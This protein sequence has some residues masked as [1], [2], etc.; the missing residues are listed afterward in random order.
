MSLLQ[1]TTRIYY[2]S[3][4]CSFPIIKTWQIGPDWHS[5]YSYGLH[6]KTFSSNCQLFLLLNCDM[7]H[8]P[9]FQEKKLTQSMKNCYLES[10]IQSLW[11]WGFKSR[12]MEFSTLPCSIFI[13]LS[14]VTGYNQD[15]VQLAYSSMWQLGTI[16]AVD[17]SPLQHVVLLTSKIMVDSEMQWGC[18]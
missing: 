5:K 13:S 3:N 18:T 11:Q 16:A 10:E 15:K 2:C 7:W 8:H 6:G 14:A 4:T 17:N 12:Y 9:S 1:Y